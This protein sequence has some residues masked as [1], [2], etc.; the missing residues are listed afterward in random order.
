MI[1]PWQNLLEGSKSLF[2]VHIDQEQLAP[3]KTYSIL[4][5]HHRDLS[6]VIHLAHLVD[7][8]YT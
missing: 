5:R 1:K 8:N 3:V 4:I 6:Q 7:K 2:F